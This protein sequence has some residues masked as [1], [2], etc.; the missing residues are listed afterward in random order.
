MEIY[1]FTMKSIQN[2]MKSFQLSEKLSGCY[3]KLSV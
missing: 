3:G 1:N 2:T